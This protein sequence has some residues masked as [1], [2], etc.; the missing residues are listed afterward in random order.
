MNGEYRERKKS[1][2][3][4]LLTVLVT[5]IIIAIVIQMSHLIHIYFENNRI[6][7]YQEENPVYNEDFANLIYRFPSM[8]RT[9]IEDVLGLP[10]GQ[11]KYYHSDLEKEI[12]IFEY[13]SDDIFDTANS[14]IELQCIDLD[15]NDSFQMPLYI[16]WSC[17]DGSLSEDEREDLL[18]FLLY[19]LKKRYGNNYKTVDVTSDTKFYKW[20][21]SY[22]DEN[23]VS[24]EELRSDNIASII[25]YDYGVGWDV[26]N[27]PLFIDGQECKEYIALIV[28][29]SLGGP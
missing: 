14:Y 27:D 7:E 29:T 25:L 10:S 28:E 21:S 20:G 16:H 11:Y 15:L 13:R 5:A 1:F 18:Q 23:P 3:G 9:E 8:Q 17:R 19:S 24:N 12:E 6:Q 4:F 22:Y 2:F 26:M